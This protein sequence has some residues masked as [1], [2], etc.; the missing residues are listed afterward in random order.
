MKFSPKNYEIPRAS[1]ARARCASSLS[2]NSTVQL[3]I[4]TFIHKYP[5]TAVLVGKYGMCIISTKFST[6]A[7]KISA[8]VILLLMYR[9]LY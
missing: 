7:G 5:G 6:G 8:G 9:G 1:T 4:S 2:V 3:Y